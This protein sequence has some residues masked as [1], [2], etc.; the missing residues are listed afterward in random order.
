MDSATTTGNMHGTLGEVW[1][2]C[3]VSEICSWTDKHW[4]RELWNTWALAHAQKNTVTERTC[5]SII[6]FILPSVLSP[7]F[8]MCSRHYDNVR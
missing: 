3:V 7:D 4:R 8:S 1:N 5:S 6:M 2:D